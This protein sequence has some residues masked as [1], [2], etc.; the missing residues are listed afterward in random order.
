VEGRL[1]AGD[2]LFVQGCGRVDLPGGDA[3]ELHRSLHQ[4]LAHLPDETELYPGHHYGPR[5]TST[6]G[7]ERRDNYALRMKDPGE[8]LRMMGA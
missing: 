7:E 2:T 8:W 5:P 1:V 6:L 3:A 4:R